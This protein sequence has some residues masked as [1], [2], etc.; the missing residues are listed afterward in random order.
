MVS[1]AL[2]REITEA[3]LDMPSG[4][5]EARDRLDAALVEANG[6]IAAAEKRR[7]ASGRL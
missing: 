3:V 6:R 2:Q 1:E 7:K 5:A 4:L